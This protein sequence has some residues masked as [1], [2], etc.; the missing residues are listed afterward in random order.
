MKFLDRF[1]IWAILAVAAVLRLWNLGYPTKLVFDETYYVKDAW[2]LSEAGH[3]LAWPTNP[4]EAFEAGD[5]N[6]F[7]TSPAYVVHPPLGKWL[8]ALGMRTFGA[9][10][11]FGWRITTALVGIALVYLAYAVA[12]RVLDSSRWGLFVAAL[13]AIDGQAIVMSRTALLDNFLAFFALLGFYFLLRDHE[14]F[15]DSI[16]R[17]PWL[18]YMGISLGAAAAVKWSGM[19][20]L[21]AFCLYAV[22]RYAIRSKQVWPSAK[23]ALATFVLTVPVALLTYVATWSGWLFTSGGYARDTDAN[24]LIAL[25]NYHVSAYKFHVG[26]SS[27]HDYSANPLTWLFMIRPTSFFYES[28]GQGCSTAIAAIGN[29]V[30]WWVGAV[31]V[32]AVFLGWITKFERNASLILLGLAGGLLPW[33]LYPNRTV[34]QFYTIAF[35]VWVLMAIAL[36]FKRNISLAARPS[37]AKKWVWVYL[38]LAAAV[39]IFFIPVWWGVKIPLWF[40]QAH[41]WLPSWI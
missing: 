38:W 20:F 30:I 34:F 29:P 13:L 17:R 25:W 24:P 31:A 7:L 22:G 5:V 4:N 10:N 16:W 2:T 26:L 37:R 3:E 9:E 11:S 19:Y 28:C 15:N 32:I 18:V 33:L 12:R 6:S 1:G 41:M 14:R 39:S 23:K 36:L 35:E 40:W 21:A 8:I 27:H